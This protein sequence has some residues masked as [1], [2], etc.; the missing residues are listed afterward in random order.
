PL[1]AALAEARDA[2]GRVADSVLESD[3][4]SARLARSIRDDAARAADALS[5]LPRSQADLALRILEGADAV[6]V[7]SPGASTAI[8]FDAL[9]PAASTGDT[10]RRTLAFRAEELLSTAVASLVDTAQPIVVLT[11]TLPGRLL[12]AAGSAGSPAARGALGAALDRLALRGVTVAEWPVALDAA[13]PARTR[14]APDGDGRPVVWF[15]FGTEGASADA[16]ARFDAYAR[17]VGALID[18]GERV[19]LSV[20]PSARPASGADDPVARALAGAGVLADTARPL[21]S[22]VRLPEGVGYDLSR[23]LGSA[24]TQTP[25]GRAIDNLPVALTWMTPVRLAEGAA[26]AEILTVPD[27]GDTWA[28]AEWLGF[29]GA[30]DDRAWSA[31]EP[32]RPNPRFDDTEGPWPVAVAVERPGMGPQ[33]LV[34]VGSPGWFFNRLA[35]RTT[36]ID[37]RTIAVYPGNLELL[38][39]AVAW[40]AGRD[41]LIAA[42]AVARDTPRIGPM[43]DARLALIRWLIILGM[44]AATLLIGAALR[45][46]LLR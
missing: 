24:N 20:A 40:A 32:P 28:E 34:V 19:V 26:G 36:E 16:A 42:G 39:A 41:D 25:I 1:A 13:R 18:E 43:P 2:A 23:V 33:R 12:D 6:L 7:L 11:H 22:R 15:C 45:Q 4:A 21:V 37:G 5:A 35:G 9:F 44:P 10:P 46:T 38:D 31:A 3:P 17:A 30:P 8:P 14:L 29:A 27:D